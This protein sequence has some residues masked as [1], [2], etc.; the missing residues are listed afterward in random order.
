MAADDDDLARLRRG[1]KAALRDLVHRHHRSMLGVARLFLH[2]RATAEEI[3]QDAWVAVLD[4]LARYE[5]RASLK[6]WIL[7]IVAN[8]AK[9]RAQRDG[10][11]VLLDDIMPAEDGDEPDR[12]DRTGHFR[13]KIAAWDTMSPERLAGDRELVRRIGDALE[14]LPPNQ[15]AVVMLRDVEGLD[16]PLICNILGIGETNLR[17]LL[18]RAR[19]RLRAVLETLVTPAGDRPI[20]KSD[21]K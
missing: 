20:G 12:F 11:V 5:A 9:T 17:V 21:D 15:R 4:G 16:A 6:T 8:K 1:D 19:T 7:A 3:V 18:H 13:E 2:N 10:V 14:A